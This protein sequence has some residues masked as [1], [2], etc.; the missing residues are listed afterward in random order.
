MSKRPAK[1]IVVIEDHPHNM[2]LIRY[3]LSSRL[4]MAPVC[5]AASGAEFL[6]WY[7]ARS[8]RSQQRAIDLILLDIQIPH[9]DGFEVLRMIRAEPGLAQTTVVAVTANVQLPILQ[10]AQAAGFD[11]F[12]G[13]PLDPE[14]FPA[15]VRQMLEQGAPIWS[16]E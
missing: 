16:I 5:S 1:Q 7:R 8:R 3:L 6:A 4:G 14:R 10:Q 9:Q 12:I 11:G 15:Q 2:E 13:K